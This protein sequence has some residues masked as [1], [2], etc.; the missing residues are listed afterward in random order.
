MLATVLLVTMLGTTITAEDDLGPWSGFGGDPAHTH[1]SEWSTETNP[2]GL[3]WELKFS[4][5]IA[6]Q[7]IF[8]G[9]GTIIVNDES[10]NVTEVHPNGT[11]LKQALLSKGCSRTPAIGPNGTLAVSADDVLFLL[12]RDL[13]VI[14]SKNFTG[15]LSSPTMAP[16]GTIHVS[17]YSGTTASSRLYAINSDGEVQWTVSDLGYGSGKVPAIGPDGTIY[18][19]GLDL[20]IR[21][22]SPQGLVLWE[23]RDNGSE[24]WYGGETAAVCV[25]PDGT[26][27]VGTTAGNMYA[28]LPNGSLKWKYEVG[29]D[30]LASASLG[31]DGTVYFSSCPNYFEDPDASQRLYALD[32]NGHKIWSYD[33]GPSVASPAAISSDGS[34]YLYVMTEGMCALGPDGDLSWIAQGWHNNYGGME[35]NSPTIGED[36][37]VYAVLNGGLMAFNIGAPCQPR[38]VRLDLHDGKAELTWK[39]PYTDGGSPVTG[40]AIYRNAYNFDLGVYEENVLVTMLNDGD[41][42]S[43]VDEGLE[44]DFHYEYS[45]CAINEHGQG[46]RAWGMIEEAANDVLLPITA[47]IIGVVVLFAVVIWYDLGRNPKE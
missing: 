9:N 35:L 46:M 41:A 23:F 19:G 17:K 14:W 2:G 37:T 45:I 26:A 7:P 30:I 18:D 21:A 44:D 42:R 4:T 43:F 16:N 38:D 47:A 15:S 11:V 29:N 25:G 40:Y 20:P 31:S 28:L 5:E 12:D 36:G 22:V 8:T 32:E 34:I 1:L 27:Y 6:G 24:G 13:E 39:P 3:A 33:Y 10:G